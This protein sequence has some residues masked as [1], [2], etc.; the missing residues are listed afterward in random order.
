MKS[1]YTFLFLVFTNYLYTANIR[2]SY[3]FELP[4]QE[5]IY[6]SNDVQCAAKIRE[7]GV[8][9]PDKNGLT[10]L[11]HAAG[12][13][14]EDMAKFLLQDPD[15]DVNATNAQGA[16]ALIIAADI[17]NTSIVN[18]LLERPNININAVD[19]FGSTALI[20]AI[21]GMKDYGNINIVKLL[22][23]HPHINIHIR[24]RA[25]HTA[26]ML[27]KVEKYHSI[28]TLMQNKIIEF[29]NR[30]FIPI[31]HHDFDGFKRLVSQIGAGIDEIRDQNGNTLLD[32][33]FKANQPDI[34]LFL[35]NNSADPIK[36]LA[37]FPFEAIQPTSEIFKLCLD[38]AFY[39][40]P[41]T[42]ESITESTKTCAQ[43]SKP[44]SI[45]RCSKCQ[46][47]YYCSTECQKLHWNK[48]KLICKR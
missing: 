41:V 32:E 42:Q 30:A 22:L 7:L 31:K 37:R 1:K 28:T 43:C 12:S 29:K 39:R 6:I 34:I 16:T 5:V 19:K 48:H 11:M 13:G 4:N 14:Y 3:I 2:K 23:S 47:A 9:K 20:V 15:I 40:D 10:A 26:T 35:L 27:A 21:N 24:N 38:L 25:G 45:H 18:L 33:A 44:S 36:L 8:N 46:N 17:G